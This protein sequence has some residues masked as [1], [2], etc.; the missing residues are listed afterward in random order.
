MI[1]NVFFFEKL[2]DFEIAFGTS[3]DPIRARPIDWWH[4]R[5]L[6]RPPNPP[7]P[8]M[9]SSSGRSKTREAPYRWVAVRPSWEGGRLLPRSVVS[10]IRV[11]P[12]NS[13]PASVVWKP[14]PRSTS[15]ADSGGLATVSG[16]GSATSRSGV[17][18]L[19]LG[20]S[21]TR[22]QNLVIFQKKKTR[23]LS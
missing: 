12:H 16:R 13:R 6:V 14:C 7:N 11:R 18:E 22:F 4:S 15:S 3:L 20:K 23:F 5:G 19:G 1:K 9:K 2:P 10:Q 17:L 8:L 21:Q